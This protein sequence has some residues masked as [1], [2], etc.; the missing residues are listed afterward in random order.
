MEMKVL[1]A[2]VVYYHIN[3][4][5]DSLARLSVYTVPSSSPSHL[6]LLP[7]FL[8]SQ[9]ALQQTLVMIILDWTKPW[10]FVDQLQFW[11]EWV[12]SWSE[13]DKSRDM[14]MIREENKEK[15]KSIDVSAS[16]Y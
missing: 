5:L 4:S 6:K 2:I 11:L 3:M 9:S 8:P 16:I 1:S 14:E 7:Y 15:C 13:G 12:E 10:T